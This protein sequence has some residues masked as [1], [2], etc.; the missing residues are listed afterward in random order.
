[1]S[2]EQ[3]TSSVKTCPFSHAIDLTDPALL[4]QG[5]PMKEFAELRK[6]A[7]V[8][9][10]EQSGTGE[11][12]NDTGFWVISKHEDIRAISKDSKL[13][14]TAAKGAI[15]RLP[16]Y[17]TPDQLET[18]RA[19]LIN[20]DPP[21]H[22]RLRKII[23]RLFTPRAVATLEEGLGRRAREIVE[24]ALA[25]GSG[26][27]VEDIAIDLP[28]QAILD[29]L[30]V[31]KEDH[32]YICKLADAIISTDD[33]DPDLSPIM[34]NAEL[35]GYAYNM[36]EERRKC[37]A[38]DILTT[39]V[40]ADV[41]GESL[42]ELEFSF[43]VVLLV[44]AGNETTRNAMSHGIK[45]FQDHPEQW[46]IYRKER[47]AT[48][49]DEIIRWATPVNGFQRTAKADTELRGVHIKAGDRVGIFY[50]SGNFDEEVFDDPFSFNV[51]RDPNPHLSFGGSGAHFCIGANLARMELNLMF[52]AIADIMPDIQIVAEPVRNRHSWL[53][54]IKQL[55][56][57]YQS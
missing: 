19:M 10:N 57:V 25:K 22:T 1:M 47:P 53:N 12:F 11:F 31:P 46:E 16:D 21:E 30:G 38:D 18:T 33:P 2:T 37:P 42:S 26:D 13:W 51:L 32:A 54:G 36:A 48:A 45:A 50:G 9:W 20:N 55:D 39:L 5:M 6:T 41:D 35:V 49:V 56:A 24:T 14:S 7:P 3:I 28:L 34:A 4:E 15:L 17:A 40:Q 52:N 44:I 8:W 29:L 43:F 23:S 27:F